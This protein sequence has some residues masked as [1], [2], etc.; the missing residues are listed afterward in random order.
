MQVGYMAIKNKKI[1]ARNVGMGIILI[2]ALLGILRV[3]FFQIIYLKP[4]F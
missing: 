4:I 3:A 1:L 2:L